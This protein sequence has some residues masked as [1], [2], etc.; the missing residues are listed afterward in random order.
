MADKKML[1]TWR[2]VMMMVNTNAPYVEM[3]WKMKIWP[4]A[5]VMERMRV[6]NMKSGWRKVKSTAGRNCPCSDSD[7]KVKKH[8]KRLMP[9][10]IWNLDIWYVLNNPDW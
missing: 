1:T 8:E 4:V 3:V 10:I 7:H 6:W 5:E 2:V 9:N